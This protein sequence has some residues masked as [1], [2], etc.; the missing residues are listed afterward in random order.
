MIKKVSP[1]RLWDHHIELESL[2]LS[3]TAHSIYELDGDV[4]ETSM[5]EQT[6]SMSSIC[7]YEWYKWV[8]FRD[9][10][11]TYPYFHVVLGQYL[12][13]ATDISSTMT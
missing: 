5:N 7:E 4:P 3:H 1:K 2:I 13:L 10:S 9:H 8:M 6:A 11:I 12:G